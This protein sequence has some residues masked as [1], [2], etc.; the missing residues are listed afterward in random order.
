MGFSLHTFVVVRQASSLIRIDS[1]NIFG[2]LVLLSWSLVGLTLLL[3]SRIRL[4]ILLGIT[5]GMAFMLGGIA[6]ILPKYFFKDVPSMN[7]FWFG[8]HVFLSLL[9]Y[10]AF[11]LAL[12]SGILY[13]ILDRQLKLKVDRPFFYRLPPLESLEFI[14]FRSLWIGAVLLG[15]GLVSGFLWTKWSDAPLRLNDPKVI[16]AWTTWAIYGLI[17]YIRTTARWRGRKV[18]YLTVLGFSSVL[19]TFFVMNYLSKGHGFF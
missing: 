11:A 4:R 17:I 13:L 16:A 15:M 10:A 12:V 14:N 7:A 18:A 2:V 8:T 3:Q 9:G 19:V 1:M 5:L 6:L